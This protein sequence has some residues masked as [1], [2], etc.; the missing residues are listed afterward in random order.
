MK[1]NYGGPWDDYQKWRR[2]A[3]EQTYGRG[4]WD[5]GVSKDKIPR[6]FEVYDNPFRSYWSK[7]HSIGILERDKRFIGV[8]CL[9][10]KEITNKESFVR[11]LGL[12]FENVQWKAASSLWTIYQDPHYSK[13]FW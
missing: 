12:S 5:E 1:N 8:A 13:R 4:S 9:A 6:G 7:E 11:R 10:A 3:Y 2:Y